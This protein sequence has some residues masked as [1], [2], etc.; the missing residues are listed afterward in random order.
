LLDFSSSFWLDL[1]TQLSGKSEVIIPG[2][3]GQILGYSSDHEFVTEYEPYDGGF[4]CGANKLLN[5][6]ELPSLPS[7]HWSDAGWL[8]FFIR[9]DRLESGSFAEVVAL[10]NPA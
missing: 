8:N 6:L 1:E 10:V 9:Q 4:R 5:L 2:E 7:M 3:W